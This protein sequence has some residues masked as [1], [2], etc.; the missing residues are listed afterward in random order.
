MENIYKEKFLN[1]LKKNNL[2]ESNDNILIAFSGGPDSVF[3]MTFLNEFKNYLKINLFACHVNHNLR[4]NATKDMEFAL[5]FCDDLQIPIAVTSVNVYEYKDLN[6]LSIEEAARILRYEALENI[7]KK[8]SCNK[9]ATAHNLNDNTETFLLNVLKGTGLKGLKG[10]PIKRDNIIRPIMC[11]TKDEIVN[12]LKK[13]NISYIIDETN[14]TNDYQRNYLRNEILP[15]LREKINPKLDNSIFNLGR[16]LEDF[17]VNLDANCNITNDKLK[18]EKSRLS[19]IS[20]YNCLSNIPN[21]EIS[22]KLIDDLFELK[23][24]KIG[25]KIVLPKNYIALND[26]DFIII[27]KDDKN[28]ENETFV[29]TIKNNF[30]KTKYFDIFVNILER[31]DVNI[32]EKETNEEFIDFDKLKSDELIIR[33]YRET[34]YFYPLG[35]KNKQ[36]L[37]DFLSNNKVPIINRKDVFVIENDEKI[38]YVIGYRIDNRFKITNN[39]KRVLKICYQ[40]ILK[41]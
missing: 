4:V 40:P 30:L 25:K 32:N 41:T 8:F 37:K 2:I 27:Y 29:L 15:K 13:N 33:K 35:L 9:I 39:T 19:K 21:L 14:L 10:I 11:F 6:K 28:I 16:I 22:Y 18:I 1:F 5:S 36:S 20:L 24:K 34:D 3:L 38:I 12:Y 7:A 23:E 17:E 26:R 31:K